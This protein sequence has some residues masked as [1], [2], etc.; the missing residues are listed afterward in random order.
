MEHDFSD[1]LRGPD[2]EPDDEYD[3]ALFIAA[4]VAV[5]IACG[6]LAWWGL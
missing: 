4:L 1:E 6:L 5:A 2:P 3:D